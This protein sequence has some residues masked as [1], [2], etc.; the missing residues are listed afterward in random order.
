MSFSDSAFPEP[1]SGGRALGLGAA[2]M[3]LSCLGLAAS[4]A[5]A[6]AATAAFTV[7]PSSPRVGQRVTFR[8]T[9]CTKAPCR[10]QWQNRPKRGRATPLHKAR[11]LSSPR[12]TYV[13]RSRGTQYVAVRKKLLGRSWSPWRYINGATGRR[14]ARGISVRRAAP[15][16]AGQPNT[17]PGTGTTPAAGAAPGGG[18]GRWIPPRNLTWY[19]QLFGTLNFDLNAQAY[20]VDPA[21]FPGIDVAGQLHARGKRAICYVNVGATESFRNDLGS[22]PATAIGSELVDW[23]GEHWL[24]IRDATVRSAMAARFRTC[25]A[26]GFDAVEPD[27]MD[28]YANN[29]G[30]SF[31][32][33]D[34]L[35]YN[36][37]IADQVHALGMAVFQK[38][39]SD[40][41]G[42]L[43]PAFD[44][45]IVEQCSERNECGRYTPYLSAG[46]PV[47][48]AEYVDSAQYCATSNALGI[49]T[50]TFSSTLD[51]P[52]AF[53]PC[54]T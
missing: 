42:A 37:W 31:T 35:S 53:R 8:T 6:R 28:G 34:Q 25:A 17:S 38:N 50:A 48:N 40:Q 4:A 32:A 12:L 47:L 22:V 18:S 19:W 3:V 1:G 41:V 46:K 21:S 44:G 49:M 51:G 30:L 16:R 54:W 39:D 27:N 36:L 29:P 5:P 10:Y 33:A 52:A 24:D 14:R 7:S 15:V 11:T 20:D 45:A 2:F 26:L 23:P 9:R 13:F 43:E